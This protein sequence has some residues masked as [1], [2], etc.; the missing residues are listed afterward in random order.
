MEE[1]RM[2]TNRSRRGIRMKKTEQ[3]W[4]RSSNA[5]KVKWKK[6]TNENKKMWTKCTNKNKLK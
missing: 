3:E 1:E 6:D 2:R 4:K 5:S